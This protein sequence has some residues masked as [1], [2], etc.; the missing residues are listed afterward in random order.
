MAHLILVLA[1]PL[2]VLVQLRLATQT[3]CS[4]RGC[5]MLALTPVPLLDAALAQQNAENIFMNFHPLNTSLQTAFH[6][7]PSR[8]NEIKMSSAAAA[9][10]GERCLIPLPFPTQRSSSTNSPVRRGERHPCYSWDAPWKCRIQLC[11][12][13]SH[14]WQQ[15]KK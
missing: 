10:L 2:C 6:H 13:W 9:E 14:R 3:Q 11:S 15:S 1:A 7:L 8:N 5:R 12:T 4:E